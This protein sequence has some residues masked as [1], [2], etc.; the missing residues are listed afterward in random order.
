MKE[1]ESQ[2]LNTERKTE[3]FCLKELCAP[4]FHSPM[5]SRTS[6]FPKQQFRRDKCEAVRLRQN[7]GT[8]KQRKEDGKP[9]KEGVVVKE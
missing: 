5:D 8:D 9:L 2:R 4:A 1:D 6:I 7:T 3:D